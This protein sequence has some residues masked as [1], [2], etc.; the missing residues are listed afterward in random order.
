MIADPWRHDTAMFW[1]HAGRHMT[2]NS[3]GKWWAT[4]PRNDM[5]KY[6]EDDKKAE[7]EK[8][9]REDFVTEEFGDRRQELI[10]IGIAMDEDAIRKALEECLL[11]SREFD[12]YRQQLRNYQDQVLSTPSRGLFGV[13]NMEHLDQQG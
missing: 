9:L 7:M 5:A 13:G 1:S 10:F 3:A 11:T 8:I 4:I 12:T 6:F 2:V